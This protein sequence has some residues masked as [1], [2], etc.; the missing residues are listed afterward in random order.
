MSLWRQLTRGL[1]ALVN[2]KGAADRDIA[3]EV[4]H[5]LDQST[6]ALVARGLPPAEAAPGRAHAS[7]AATP[8]S[9]ERV[10][11]YGWENRSPP[12]SPI[13]ATPRAACARNPGF[14]AVCVLTLALGIGA[15]RRHLQ[16]Y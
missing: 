5:Y 2:R 13:C 11:S 9:R 1:R 15:S 14:T 8:Q 16:R 12:R 3:D 6:A 10:R 7:S 4:E